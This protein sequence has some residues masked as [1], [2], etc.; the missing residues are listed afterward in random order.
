MIIA[1]GYYVDECVIPYS[2]RKGIGDV[3]RKKWQSIGL[4]DFNVDNDTPTSSTAV[5]NGFEFQ[6]YVGIYLVLKNFGS[7][8]ALKN[9]RRVSNCCYL[10]E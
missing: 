9:Q 1:C 6:K 10:K 7:F 4:I 5:M 8:K 2:P 3:W